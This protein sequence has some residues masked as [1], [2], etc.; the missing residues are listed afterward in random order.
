MRTFKLFFQI[1]SHTIFFFQEIHPHIWKSYTLKLNDSK[2]NRCKSSCCWLINWAQQPHFFTLCMMWRL[3]TYY[4]LYS[5]TPFIS[6][7]PVSLSCSQKNSHCTFCTSDKSTHLNHMYR[8]SRTD[9][10]KNVSFLKLSD[11]H[12]EFLDIRISKW[13]VS[14]SDKLMSKWDFPPLSW[15]SQPLT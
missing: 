4:C 14:V 12:V 1:I 10:E 8:K 9:E 2:S 15:R 7:R 6:L 13:Q 3:H 5:P 11:I